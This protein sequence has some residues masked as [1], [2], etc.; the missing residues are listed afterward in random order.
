MNIQ[1]IR[2]RPDLCQATPEDVP[3]FLAC[4]DHGWTWACQSKAEAHE[5]AQSPTEWCEDCLHAEILDT[6]YQA[7]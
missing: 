5:L 1:I 3:F 4:N 2:N 6:D 7:N